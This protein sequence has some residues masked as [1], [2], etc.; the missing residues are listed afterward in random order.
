MK[1]TDTC[2]QSVIRQRL[3]DAT[4]EELLEILIGYADSKA[5]RLDWFPHYLAADHRCRRLEGREF[6]AG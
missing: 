2:G 1:P 3:A 4:R 5:G 6:K